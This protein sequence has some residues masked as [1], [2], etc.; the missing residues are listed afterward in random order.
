MWSGVRE[1]KRAK[2]EERNEEWSSVA[3]AGAPSSPRKPSHA[4]QKHRAMM[5]ER[6]MDG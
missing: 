5:D 2:R 1:G 6:N 4:M 3:M